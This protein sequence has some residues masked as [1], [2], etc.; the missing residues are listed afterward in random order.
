MSNKK[1]LIDELTN[2]VFIRLNEQ[3]SLNENYKETLRKKLV[4]IILSVLGLGGSMASFLNTPEGKKQ[5]ED[6][7]EEI[8]DNAVRLGYA[9]DEVKAVIFQKYIESPSEYSRGF[10]V[11][12]V[13]EDYKDRQLINYADYNRKLEKQAINNA[14]TIQ[15]IKQKKAIEFKQALESSA[16]LGPR[17]ETEILDQNRK[18]L[19]EELQRQYKEHLARIQEIEKEFKEVRDRIRIERDQKLRKLRADFRRVPSAYWD[20][21]MEEYKPYNPY[22]EP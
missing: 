2:R 13:E 19:G 8:I 21:S 18:E 5:I 12:M 17:N 11:T 1:A 7:K 3:H 20:S 16:G 10:R 14:R 9:S 15:T 6:N 22:L 4:P